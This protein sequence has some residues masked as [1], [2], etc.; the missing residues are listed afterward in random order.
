MTVTEAQPLTHCS[1]YDL[2]S[3]PEG[4]PVGA[5]PGDGWLVEITRKHTG[6]TWTERVIAWVLQR[7]GTAMPLC[8]EDSSAGATFFPTL[9]PELRCRVYHPAA[10]QGEA[11]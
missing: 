9:D 8:L 6:L 1:P 4:P 2:T 11:P 10:P 7:G 3:H 5:A